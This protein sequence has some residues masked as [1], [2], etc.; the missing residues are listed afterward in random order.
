LPPPAYLLSV[1]GGPSGWDDTRRVAVS[2]LDGSWVTSF[3]YIS[4]W[5]TDYVFFLA[6]DHATYDMDIFDYSGR[7]LYNTRDLPWVSDISPQ[8]MHGGNIRGNASEGFSHEAMSDGTV[9][10]IELLTG[11]IIRTEFTRASRFYDG[12]AAVFD[13]SLWGFVNTDFELVIPHIYQDDFNFVYGRA[14]VIL[15]DGRQQIINRRG[16]TLLEVVYNEFIEQC[17]HGS[18]Y[19]IH[20]SNRRPLRVYT[21][22]LTAIPLPMPNDDRSWVSA[23]GNGWFLMQ[24]DGV[25]AVFSTH[26]AYLFPDVNHITNVGDNFVI[27]Y[28][29]SNIAESFLEAQGVLALDGSEIIPPQENAWITP[30]LDGFAATAFIVNANIRGPINPIDGSTGPPRQ[31]YSLYSIDGNLLASGRGWLSHEPGSGVFA[32]L[33]EDHYA[34][35][36]MNGNVIFR[37]PFLSQTLD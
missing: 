16:E 34:H 3:D 36:D 5:F 1:G 4:A 10:F 19:I 32:V 18:G 27:Y 17:W 22:N 33:A 26:G 14:L 37:I 6:H 28:N 29:F 11:R 15:P 12:L 31:V 7:L 20:D 21:S 24:T 35:L 2:A 9:A 8:S 25:T 13:G 30:V 23:N